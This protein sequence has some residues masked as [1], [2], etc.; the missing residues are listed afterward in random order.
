MTH[1]ALYRAWR[2]Q[3]FQDMVG[4]QHII[5]TLQNAIR[6][7]RVSH[8]Y[9]FN[10][11][12]GTGKTTA[13]KVLAKAVNCERGPATEPCNECDACRGITAGH[14]MDVVEIDAAS[15]RG[16]DEIRDIRDKVRYAPSEVR[17]KVY[18][19]DEVH[20]LTAEAFNALL[21]TLEEP[22]GHV[23][24]ILATTE[25]HKLPATIISRCQR[26]DFRQVSL[27]EQS[28][29][30][31]QICRE[32]GIDADEDAISYIARLSEGGMRDAISLLEQ[33]SAFGNSRITLE[34][35]VDV[36]GGMAA[37]Q[38]YELA[39]AVRDRNVA[40]VLPLVE[41]LTQAGKSADKCME[42]LI[43]Y[44]RDLL[45]LKLAPQGAAT[46]RVVDAERFRSM[47]E[48][49]T[50]ERL[51]K[52]IDTLNRYQSDMKHASQPQTLFEVA[53][54][55]LCTGDAHSAASS[56]SASAGEAPSA[57]AAP[58]TGEMQ[59]LRQQVEVL[60]RK[61]EQL[62]QNGGAAA[63]GGQAGD[64]AQSRAAGN[65]QPGAGG[66]GSFGGTGG[67][68]GVRL[69]AVKLDPYLGV[70]GSPASGQ[71]R[72]KWSEVLQR[73]K[74]AR[75]TVHAWLVDGEPVSV[76]DDSVLVA[77]KNTM[78]RETTEKP[79]HR[80]IIERVLQ[81]VIGTPLR[82]ATVMLKDWQAAVDRSGG[83]GGAEDPLEL[84]A[85]AIDTGEAAPQPK[86]VEEAVKLF[87]EDL[88][89]VK[90]D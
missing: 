72:M 64:G 16:I 45:V 73:V 59:R 80:E 24:F 76:T 12:R 13:A 47:A 27:A 28:E 44:F 71:V 51:F 86:W 31:I 68:G 18:I 22:P 37:E 85:D 40:A 57:G 63:G 82:L 19:I 49:F 62:L 56:S 3:T 75:I 26:F 66:R 43:Y 74:E 41:S 46:E 89:V 4:Q 42:N 6:E 70:A 35:A 52:M 78:H 65:R 53:L 90:E 39:E 77:F 5:Q 8:A 34:A 2:P 21:K 55:K 48:A 15:N 11:P 10:G 83:G 69:A 20:M 81:D 38:F 25:P 67:A 50:P 54:M 23:I 7:N 32:E 84:T 33:V 88:V 29:R 36:T 61:L 87:G 30:L 1:I 14:I 79:A 17:Y 9:L 58:A 60:E